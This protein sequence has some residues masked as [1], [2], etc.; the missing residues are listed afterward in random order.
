VEEL[1]DDD[2]L[3]EVDLSEEPDLSDELALDDDEDDSEPLLEL[4][5]VELLPDSRLSVR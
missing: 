4:L 5:V 2:V 3:D 1:L